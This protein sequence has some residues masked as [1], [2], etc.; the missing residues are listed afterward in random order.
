MK[1]KSFGCAGWLF[2]FT[3]KINNPYKEKKYIPLRIV[4]IKI[5]YTSVFIRFLGDL[6][7]I[8]IRKCKHI[9]G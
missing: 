3:H 4:Y 7:I 1:K 9:E 5:L 8:Y 2:V 6:M